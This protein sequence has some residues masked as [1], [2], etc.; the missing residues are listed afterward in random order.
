MHFKIDGE[1]QK[2]IM[3]DE[4]VMTIFENMCTDDVRL[5]GFDPTYSHPR[6][7]IL[8]TL[9]VLPSA[10][11]PFVVSDNVTC[12]DDL[13]IQYLE[14]IKANTHLAAFDENLHDVRRQHYIQ[15]LKFRIKCLFDNSQERSKHSNGRPLKGIKKRLTGKEGQLRNNL[16]GK[17]VDKSA[18]S[19]IGPDPTLAVDEIA[20]PP[21]IADILTFPERVTQLNKEYLEHLLH[22]HQVNYVIRKGTHVRINTKYVLYKHHDRLHYGDYIRKRATGELICIRHEKQLFLYEEGDIVLRD[23]EILRDFQA[24]TRKEFELHIGDTVERKLHDGDIVLL[25]R[26]PTLHKGSMIAFNVRI[27]EGKTIRLNLAVTKSFNAD[28]DGD[29]MNIHAPNDVDSAAELRLLSSLPNHLISHQSSKPNIVIVQDGLLGAYMMS[30]YTRHIPQRHVNTILYAS[31]DD[32]VIASLDDKR[33]LFR[34]LAPDAHDSQPDYTNGKILFSCLLPSD[35]CYAHAGVRIQQGILLDGHITKAH[36]GSSHSSL[37]VHLSHIYT[38][39]VCIDFL[40]KLQFMANEFLLFHGFSIGLGDCILP[41]G[42]P[43]KIQYECDKSLLQAHSY[44][45]AVQTPSLREHCI[46]RQL[47]NTRNV[48]M[49]IAKDSLP[50]TNNFLKTITSGSKGDIFNI[51][52]IMGLLGQQNI[53][54]Q[55]VPKTMTNGTRTMCHFPLEKTADDGHTFN[56][57]GFI[58]GCFIRGLK[59][60]DFWFHAMTGREGITD[61]AM[62]TATSGYI[63]RRMVK[64]AEDVQVRYDGT[65]R[66]GSQSIFQF[67]YGN[68]GLDPSRSVIYTDTKGDKHVTFADVQSIANRLNCRRE[69]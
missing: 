32:N 8:H 26:Q 68:H 47:N 14:I 12:D 23:G 15:S 63:Q 66:N 4:E 5:L 41:R 42:V 13:T 33:R 59:P 54:G 50:P 25:N 28:F 7:L 49:K 52:Q 56:T 30:A 67:M 44:H 3:Y 16:M 46:A 55:R 1:Q 69:S 17:R 58:E 29:E 2:S 37:I 45:D 22:T 6:C 24:P 20:V 40:S 9:P 60:N 51:T 27:R 36:L 39:D 65:V 64:I 10:A 34:Q 62:K 38:I 53:N 43:E 31:N 57:Q 48:C 35:F 18:R 19:V 11:R 21:Q 61:T